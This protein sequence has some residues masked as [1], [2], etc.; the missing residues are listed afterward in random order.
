MMGSALG[1]SPASGDNNVSGT[2]CL[3]LEMHRASAVE[4]LFSK[5]G[6]CAEHVRECNNIQKHTEHSFLRP[7]IGTNACLI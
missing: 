5:K 7:E 4:Y 1:T 6:G 2:A 3:L